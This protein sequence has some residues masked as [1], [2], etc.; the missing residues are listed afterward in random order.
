[1]PAADPTAA[2]QARRILVFGVTGSGKSTAAIRIAANLGLP[3]HLADE[4]TWEPGWMAVDPVEQRRRFAALAAEPR[5]VLDTAYSGWSDLVVPRTELIVGLD[6]PRWFSF[7]RLVRRTVARIV[8]RRPICNGNVET[9]RTALGADSI[10]RWHFRSFAGKRERMRRWYA[11]QKG[12][13]VLMFT[14]GRDL[15]AW[16]GRL[17]HS[18]AGDVR[19]EP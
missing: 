12:P 19:R 14:R 13:A 8:D 2:G 18:P 17:R 15:D 5:W 11:A 1:V 4:L 7:Q 16:I 10:L 6:F 9:I 3:C